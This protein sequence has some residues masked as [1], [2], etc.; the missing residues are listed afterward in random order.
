MTD[1]LTRKQRSERMAL[2][3]G[4]NTGLGKLSY[5]SSAGSSYRII[6]TISKEPKTLTTQ[7]INDIAIRIDTTKVAQLSL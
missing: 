7:P 1:T 4:K 5:S 3:R 2:I 6:R